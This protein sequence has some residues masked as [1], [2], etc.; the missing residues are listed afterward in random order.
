MNIEDKIEAARTQFVK[1][2]NGLPFT[3]LDRYNGVPYVIRPGQHENLPLDAAVHILGYS[4]PMDVKCMELHVCKRM[5][6]NTL[7]FLEV[8]PKTKKNK[9]QTYF[10]ALKIEPVVYKLVKVDES[11]PD[12][13]NAPIPADPEV[14]SAAQ[15]R[16]RHAMRPFGAGAST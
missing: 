14:P 11:E 10:E 6:W 2:T 13:P 9:A 15:E 7:E 5:G 1:V 4:E 8:D 3:V 16:R 12:D